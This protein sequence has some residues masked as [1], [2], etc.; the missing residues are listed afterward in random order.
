VPTHGTVIVGV[1]GPLAAGKSALSQCLAGL[2]ARVID[3]DGLGH[4]VLAT[5][6]VAAEVVRAFGAAMTGSE[7]TLDRAAMARVVFA[8]A[9]AR[10]RLEAIVHPA[11]R[12]VIDREV[13][14]ARSAGTAAVVIDCALLF[15]SG[16]DAMCDVV[17]DV[18]APREVRLARA[19]QNR[20]WD[21][22]EVA[23]REAAQLPAAEKASR[24]DRVVV[25][26]GDRAHLEDEARALFE[27]IA[28]GSVPR[29]ATRRG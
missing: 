1:T 5:S 15:E 22:A 18:D 26:D 9:G 12:R 20:G 6:E 17:V 25:N 28:R 23:R 7:G 24:S 19:A 27:E 10:R 16:L 13:A 4:R 2:G 29:D 21:E 14:E 8:D 3:V 11:V